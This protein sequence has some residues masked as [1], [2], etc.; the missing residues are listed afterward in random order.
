[1]A[2]VTPSSSSWKRAM[3][4][5]RAFT[6]CRVRGAALGSPLNAALRARS[7]SR[8][9]PAGPP[10]LLSAL[11]YIGNLPGILPD[12]RGQHSSPPSDS[13]GPYSAWAPTS[14]QMVFSN[15]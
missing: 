9:R 12:E 10:V 7:P 14:L 4:C 13:P 2:A 6:P 5:R 1:L 15:R 11:L 3:R 8:R